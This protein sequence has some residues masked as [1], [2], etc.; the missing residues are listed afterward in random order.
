MVVAVAVV[1]LPVWLLVALPFALGAASWFGDE[2]AA[3]AEV[4]EGHVVFFG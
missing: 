3:G 1:G 4:G 2:G